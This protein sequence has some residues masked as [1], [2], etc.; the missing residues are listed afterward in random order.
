M[1]NAASVTLA[2]ILVLSSSVALAGKP[3]SESEATLSL[4]ESTAAFD[5]SALG[6]YVAAGAGLALGDLGLDAM[7]GNPRQLFLPDVDTES[8]SINL[9]GGYR[10][11]RRLAA[12]MLWDFQ[13]GWNA[14]AS[15]KRATLT[16]WNLTANIKGYLTETQWQPF[17]VA[18][19][20]LG[21]RETDSGVRYRN[22]LDGTVSRFHNEDEAFVARVGLG[23]DVHLTEA[24]T[25]GGEAVY[26]LGTGDLNS[27]D[28]A[29]TTVVLAYMFH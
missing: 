10:F 15:D 8:A 5:F 20:G 7:G 1:M 2:L 25:F 6:P 21:Q 27:L 12:E 13:T 18:G 24:W 9:R 17:V 28:Y 14:R 11:H 29:T 26:V 4:R 19:I 3:V 22:Y 16:A 23:L